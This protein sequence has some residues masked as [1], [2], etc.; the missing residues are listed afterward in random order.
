MIKINSR[1]YNSYTTKI[2]WGDFEVVSQGKKRT[3]KAPFVKFNI[4]NCIF[5][6][7]ELTFSQEMFETLKLETHSNISQYVSDIT[8]EDENG[9][10]SIIDGDYNCMIT[11]TSTNKFKINLSA[12]ARFDELKLLV[13]TDIEL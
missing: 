1:E 11:K 5:T 8:Y 2:I 13:N 7:I 4:E 12:N 9:W 3:G 10:I 6:G